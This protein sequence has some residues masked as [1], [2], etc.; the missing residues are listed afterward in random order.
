MPSKNRPNQRLSLL[1]FQSKQNQSKKL[2]NIRTKRVN[3]SWFS[4]A[5]EIFH[6]LQ[7]KR[8]Q[9]PIS[10]PSQLWQIE[11][12]C[13]RNQLRLCKI[14]HI[15]QASGSPMINFWVVSG[16]ALAAKNHRS[17]PFLR[18]SIGPTHTVR[19]P[20]S[21]AFKAGPPRGDC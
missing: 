12:L 4:L 19:S 16:K 7:Q 15:I 14:E 5:S 18:N 6:E 13:N 2:S 21:P 1:K 20:P 3:F 11:V 17:L 10:Q 9:Y 8:A